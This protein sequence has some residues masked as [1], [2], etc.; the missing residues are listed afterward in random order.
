MRLLVCG[1]RG[2]EDDRLVGNVMM[3]EK[4]QEEDHCYVL[5][6][7][8]DCTLIH[9]DARGVDSSAKVNARAWGWHV[10]DFPADWSLGRKAGPMRNQRMLDEGKPHRVLAFWDGKSRGTLDMIRRAVKAG[11]P[12]RIVPVEVGA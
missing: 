1:C 8:E 9:G 12:V 6:E 5:L 11:V 4:L 10:E 2:F 7:P 3:V